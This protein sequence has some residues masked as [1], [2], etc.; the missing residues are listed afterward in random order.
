MNRKK[1]TL[2]QV[3]YLTLKNLVKIH[4]RLM[5][6]NIQLKK[7]IVNLFKKLKK[8]LKKKELKVTLPNIVVVK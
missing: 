5:V 8:K 6:K 7:V 2:L 3:L 1:V 4:L